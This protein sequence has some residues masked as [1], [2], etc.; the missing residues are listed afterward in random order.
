MRKQAFWPWWKTHSHQLR[1]PTRKPVS[2]E[3]ITPPDNSRARMAALAAAK[4]WRAPK[5]NVDQRAFADGKAKHVAHQ[6]RQPLEADPLREAQ[7]EDEGAQVGAIG[8]AWL[9]PRRGLGLEPS[10]ATGADA[11]MQ[12]HP[13]DLGR[14]R[15]KLDPVID[16]ARLLRAL[17]DLGPATPARLRQNIAAMRRVGMQRPMRARMRLLLATVLDELGR[18]LLAAARRDARI[19]RRLG[20]TIKLGPQF[21]EFGPKRR[22]LRAQPPD[23][24][25]LRQRHPDQAFPIQRIKSGAIHPKLE[26]KPNSP[27][28]PQIAPPFELT[29]GG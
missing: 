12:A 4:R 25:R 23:R 27:V 26:S 28:K 18:R 2:S 13:R 1:L 5:E 9:K 21:G 7:I 19:V 14:N 29:P 20:R 16:L 8:G 17:R 10:C 24:L 11:S 6:A 15:G 3:Q 22:R